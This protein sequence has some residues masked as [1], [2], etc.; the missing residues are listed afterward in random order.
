[1]TELVPNFDVVSALAEGNGEGK[2]AIVLLIRHAVD[3]EYTAWVDAVLRRLSE[4]DGRVVWVG[5]N[6]EPIVGDPDRRWDSIAVVEFPSRGAFLELVGA[7]GW[8]RVEGLRMAGMHENEIYG[9]TPVV[10]AV[11]RD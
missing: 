1:M 9:C 8:N 7:S 5:N 2:F 6:G 10:D 11:D 3:E 4:V